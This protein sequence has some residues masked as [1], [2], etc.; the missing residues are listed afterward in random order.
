VT[1]P[2]VPTRH[3][4]I[5]VRVKI[6]GG[7]IVDIVTVQVPIGGRST[8]IN[9]RAVPILRQQALTVQSARVDTVS[10]ATNTSEAYRRSLQAALDG[11]AHGQ[12]T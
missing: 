1:G 6:T 12:R 10:G 5:Q 8:E 9:Q 11:A 3:G 2:V 7:R 4:Q